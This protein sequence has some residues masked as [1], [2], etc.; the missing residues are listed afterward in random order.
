MNGEPSVIFQGPRL[1]G[2][3]WMT[4][5]HMSPEKP[6]L[7]T[8]RT[9][10][11]GWVWAA[12]LVAL[13]ALAGSLWLSMGMGLKACPLCFYQRTFVMAPVAVLV[14][15]LPGRVSRPT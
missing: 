15:G 5:T 2:K 12:L 8:A 3:V 4:Q 10:T 6:V 11:S 13:I 7:S 1:S 14:F 9:S